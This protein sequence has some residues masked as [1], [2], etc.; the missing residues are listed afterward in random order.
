MVGRV[1]NHLESHQ[2]VAEYFTRR[3]VYLVTAKWIGMRIKVPNEFCSIVVTNCYKRSNFSGS[4]D[5]Q[6]Y[7]SGCLNT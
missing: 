6:L 1:D 4:T 3:K 5:W 2:S 7:F